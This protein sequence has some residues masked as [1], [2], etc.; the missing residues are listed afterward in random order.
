MALSDCP[1]AAAEKCDRGD[2]RSRPVPAQI[3]TAL[4]AVG[5]CLTWRSICQIPSATMLGSINLSNNFTSASQT[6]VT[7]LM[8][9]STLAWSSTSNCTLADLLVYV[10]W[11]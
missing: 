9:S 2:G 4:L 5:V 3:K 11:V 7:G 10:S 6:G 8:L 1:G